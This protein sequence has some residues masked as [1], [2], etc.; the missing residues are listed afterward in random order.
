MDTPNLT[1]GRSVVEIDGLAKSEYRSFVKALKAHYRLKQD[2]P[3]SSVKL[4]DADE[5][6][7]SFAN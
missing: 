5:D 4:R 1:H 3:N 2:F 7:S 6:P